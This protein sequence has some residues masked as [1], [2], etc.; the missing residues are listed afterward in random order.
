MKSSIIKPAAPV[1]T[2][3][4]WLLL[5]QPAQCFYS[6]STGRW[7]SRDPVGEQGGLHLSR[8]VRNN[9]VQNV[10][11]FGLEARGAPQPIT[12]EQ[13]AAQD[14]WN[15]LGC[16]DC[17]VA[18]L[19]QREQI[20]L[21]NVI[22]L[23]DWSKKCRTLKDYASLSTQAGVLSTAGGYTSDELKKMPACIRKAFEWVEGQNVLTAVTYVNIVNLWLN[24]LSETPW[25][26]LGSA[27][28]G[29]EA[30][31]QKWLY[32]RLAVVEKRCDALKNQIPQAPKN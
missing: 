27:L 1:L 2:V 6:P 14:E 7:L 29:S 11:P 18:A 17:P 31:R 23:V 26:C 25:C 12:P 28:G 22:Y 30:L 5:T 20:A 16:G 24:P 3:I 19:H 13:Q 21:D 15:K 9:P 32:Q 4:T 10:D 8:F